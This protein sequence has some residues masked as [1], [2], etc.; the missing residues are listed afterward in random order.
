MPEAPI[1]AKKNK[2]SL[3]S[4]LIEPF[5]QIRFG[6]YMIG[7]ALSFMVLI[8]GFFFYS[9]YKQYEQVMEIFHIVDPEVKWDMILNDVFY[10]NSYILLGMLASFFS[11]F[12][13][14]VFRETHKY[15]GPLVSIKRFLNELKQGHY[16]NRARIRKNDELQALVVELNSLAEI[17]EKKHGGSS[18]RT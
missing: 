18:P 2:R 5:A 9:F 8:I 14:I 15:Y 16:Q 7:C 10:A 6:L 3:R 13:W 1:A 4:L 17:L 11:V 12:F